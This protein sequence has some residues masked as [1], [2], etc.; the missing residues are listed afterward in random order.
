MHRINSNLKKLNDRIEL[1]EEVLRQTGRIELNDWYYAQNIKIIIKIYQGMSLISPFKD[2]RD[3]GGL[4]T[5][6]RLATN[7]SKANLNQRS[8]IYERQ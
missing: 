4:V 3:I 7:T 2:Y 5:K 1:N 6:S 8:H